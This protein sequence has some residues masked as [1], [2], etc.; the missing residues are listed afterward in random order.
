MSV[1][2]KQRQRNRIMLALKNKIIGALRQIR[3]ADFS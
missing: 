3:I 2:K 1:S